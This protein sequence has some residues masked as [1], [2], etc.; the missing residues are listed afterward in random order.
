MYHRDSLLDR[1]KGYCVVSYHMVCNWEIYYTLKKNIL[2]MRNG[3]F[4]INKEGYMWEQ[5][6]FTSER[7]THNKYIELVFCILKKLPWDKLHNNVTV[8]LH[9]INYI[10]SLMLVLM[11]IGDIIEMA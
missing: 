6:K 3:L 8:S 11:F 1:G 5:H 7:G 9:W 10:S 2:Q 4:E